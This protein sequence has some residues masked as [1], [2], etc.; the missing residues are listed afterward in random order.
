MGLSDR[1]DRIESDQWV[2]DAGAVLDAVGSRRAVILGISAGAPTAAL[3]ASRHPAR[4]SALVLYGGYPRFLRGDGYDIG[5]D[6][7]VV[8][9]VI[10]TM[11]AKWGTGVGISILAPS[12]SDDPV[13]RGF[14]ARLQAVSASPGAA[15][16]FLRTLASVDIRDALPTIRVPT[17]LL[18]PERDA[19]TPI[20][21]AR[22]CQQLIPGARLVELDS[23]VH[24]I[25]LSDVIGVIATEIETFI[26]E[27]V[28]DRDAQPTLVTLLAIEAGETGS[29]GSVVDAVVV[30]HGGRLLPSRAIAT[31]ASPGRALTCALALVTEAATG[32]VAVG[33]HTGEC[34]SDAR[35]VRG[36][37]VD[38][39]TELAA[40]A[41]P[42]EVLV[43][44]TV[45][46]LLAG[47]DRVFT[48]RGR[49]TGG[50]VPGEWESLVATAGSEADR[51]RRC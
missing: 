42:G 31:F 4:C 37:A 16:T 29:L 5:A 20:E 33:I 32:A 39:A 9:A 35:G 15:A 49:L 45:R 50:A 17:L 41:A 34:M 43:S 1:P 6:P 21:G 46:D 26:D 18:H 47:S 14:W 2:D 28:I 23:D 22:L 36:I 30:R 24:L 27:V 10:D 19:N 48:P 7:D 12:R 38:V 11:E 51:A 40:E 25:W 8:E 44:Q 3:F 13:A